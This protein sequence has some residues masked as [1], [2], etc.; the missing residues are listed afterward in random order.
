M[1]LRLDLHTIL[2]AITP[3]VYFQSPPIK[4]MQ[5][6]CIVYERDDEDKKFAGNRPYNHT[7]RYQVTV[8]D[9][10]PDSAIVTSVTGLPLCTFDR[11]FAANE[12]NHDV[13]TLYY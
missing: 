5:Y 11:H 6:P 4:E 1:G 12:L 7:W 13:F 8:I 10:D 9:P 3:H 2:V